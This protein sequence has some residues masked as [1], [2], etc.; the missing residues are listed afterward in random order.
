MPEYRGTPDDPN[1]SR[2][3]ASTAGIGFAVGCSI[4]IL[5]AAPGVLWFAA[6]NPFL[7][8]DLLLGLPVV[9]D[10]DSRPLPDLM[11]AEFLAEQPLAAVDTYER[12]CELR[13]PRATAE[14][15]PKE[16]EERLRALGYVQ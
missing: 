13:R 7:I 10:M 3:I 16:V 12:G 2:R 11:T 15:L 6:Q 1:R 4:G 5:G 9:K 14:E 8:D